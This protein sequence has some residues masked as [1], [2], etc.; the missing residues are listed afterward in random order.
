MRT[1]HSPKLSITDQINKQPNRPLKKRLLSLAEN[2]LT[3]Q[4]KNSPDQNHCETNIDFNSQQIIADSASTESSTSPLQKRV[5]RSTKRLLSDN[6]IQIN[7]SKKTKSDVTCSH[8]SQTV[9]SNS[10]TPTHTLTTNE[11]IKNFTDSIPTHLHTTEKSLVNISSEKKPDLLTKPAIF[12]LIIKPNEE[13]K[14]EEAK[15][16]PESDPDIQIIN[17]CDNSSKPNDYEAFYTSHMMR[18]HDINRIKYSNNIL[19]ELKKTDNKL[20]TYFEENEVTDDLVNTFNIKIPNYKNQNSYITKMIKSVQ[21][22]SIKYAFLF[23]STVLEFSVNSAFAGQKI[24]QAVKNLLLINELNI[25][26]GQNRIESIKHI[27]LNEK[28]MLMQAHISSV[29]DNLMLCLE[30]FYLPKNNDQKLEFNKI[31]LRT[32]NQYYHD[33]PGSIETKELISLRRLM[34]F[35]IPEEQL[36]LENRIFKWIS[37]KNISVKIIEELDK[38]YKKMEQEFHD[39]FSDINLH[40]IPIPENFINTTFAYY[41][42]WKYFLTKCFCLLNKIKLDFQANN[43]NHNLNK[44]DS[45]ELANQEEF[46]VVD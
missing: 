16:W 4:P 10:T 21:I 33:Y 15:P 23:K 19:K 12:L 45:D 5:L 22:D 3:I 18:D 39:H 30:T 44:V 46:I 42:E 8:S 34:L 26:Y 13:V 31:Q 28:K 27:R 9:N 6:Q 38:S 24:F 37:Y 11:N 29:Y 7:Q 36:Q 2:V 43:P 40:T 41:F 17:I 1:T 32:I 20:I 14:K 25:E 35:C